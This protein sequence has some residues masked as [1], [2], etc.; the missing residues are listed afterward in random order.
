MGI[1]GVAGS[2]M[3]LIAGVGMPISMNHLVDKAYNT[4]FYTLNAW[5]LLITIKQ[6]KLIKVKGDKLTEL[7]F[8]K[9]MVI[10]VS[11]LLLVMVILLMQGLANNKSVEKG[12]IYVTN[13]FAELAGIKK[14]KLWK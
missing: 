7:I 9:M 5:R 12:G 11:W 2:M 10:I 13:R 6:L 14:E 3:L 4:D 1:V 8:Q